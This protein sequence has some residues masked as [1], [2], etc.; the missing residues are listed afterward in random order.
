MRPPRRKVVGS[1]RAWTG[2]RLGNTGDLQ[3]RWRNNVSTNSKAPRQCRIASP[4]ADHRA[5][6]EYLLAHSLR[7]PE[8]L[9]ELRETTASM[10]H[11]GMQISPDQG[12]FMGAPRAPHGRA[13]HDRGRRLHRL[14]LAQRWRSPC[15]PDG[16]IVACDVSEEWTAIARELL[17]EGGGREEDRLEARARARDAR[18][19]RRRGRG[20]DSTTSR[21]ST[22]TRARY[23]ATT[24]AASTLLRQRRPDRDGQHAVVG[25]RRR[26]G[27]RRTRTPRAIR[28]LQRLRCTPTRAW[29]LA[30]PAGRRRHAALKL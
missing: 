5:V 10:K 8:V 19:A 24:S 15:P 22:P 28:A 25:G 20:A 29:R 17:G 26:P 23:A 2:H 13:A 11:G 30:A 21:S 1:R 12:Q 14:Q 7:E 4:P 16:R 18:R 3:S 6:Y 27:A 9:R